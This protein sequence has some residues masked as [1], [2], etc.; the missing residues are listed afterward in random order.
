MS[1]LIGLGLDPSEVEAL[2]I[3]DWPQECSPMPIYKDQP[4]ELRDDSFFVEWMAEGVKVCP[5]KTLSTSCCEAKIL[6]FDQD[7][8]D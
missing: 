7:L 5:G 6:I 2:S 3:V 1:K 4:G 8:L